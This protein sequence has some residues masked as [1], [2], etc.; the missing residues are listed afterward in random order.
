MT[1]YQRLS[2]AWLEL[3][4]CETEGMGF[5]HV[6]KPHSYKEMYPPVL[7]KHWIK[8]NKWNYDSCVICLP[9]RGSHGKELAQVYKRLG[10]K[11]FIVGVTP[12][13][14]SWY[15]MPNGIYDQIDAVN[16]IK[17]AIDVIEKVIS[18]IENKRRI[19]RNKMVLLGH[20][21]GA[22]MAIMTALASKSPFAGVISHNGAI[23]APEVVTQCTC[24]NMPILLTHSRD[25]LIFEWNERFV[26]MF[27]SL[28]T[29][30]YK[31]YTDVE[32][33]AGHCVTRRK[34]EIGKYF[35]QA[36]LKQ[37]KNS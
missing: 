19:P 20:S 30:G 31:V 22:V 7:E 25:D 34:F 5:H 10:V 17:P 36:C 28:K 23:L 16:G 18:A 1:R 11:S 37:S 12:Q 4:D 14:R 8:Y 9:G 26:P 24:P 35:I 33:D 3:F 2:P 32:S 27:Q 6:C 13:I 21:A 15:P 29:N